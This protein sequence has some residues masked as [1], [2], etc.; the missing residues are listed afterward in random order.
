MGKLTAT[1]TPELKLE[2]EAMQRTTASYCDE[3]NRRYQQLLDNDKCLKNEQDKFEETFGESEVYSAKEKEKL[4]L[5]ENEAT[6]TVV[7]TELNEESEN[8]VQNAVVAAVLKALTQKVDD[9]AKMLPAALPTSEDAGKIIKIDAD[10]QAVWAEDYGSSLQA[11]YPDFYA[12][13]YDVDATDRKHIVTAY[14][15]GRK[16]VVAFAD[17]GSITQTLYNA[18]GGIIA[19]RETTFSDD[20][21]HISERKVDVNELGQSDM[22]S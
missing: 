22:D 3:W 4:R 1:G 18:D 12:P 9:L 20:K 15:D 7:D 19:Q 6:K 21:K 13:D 17:D 2:M 5:I 8:P 14:A 10:G 16:A 11:K